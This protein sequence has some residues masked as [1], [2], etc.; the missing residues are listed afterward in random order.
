MPSSIWATSPVTNTNPCSFSA[1][2]SPTKI[3][4]SVMSY[5]LRLA[6]ATISVVNSSELVSEEVL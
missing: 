5:S 1:V 3:V 6:Y 2:I 4:A